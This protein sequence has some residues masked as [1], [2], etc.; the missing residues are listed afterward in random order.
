MAKLDTIYLIMIVVLGFIFNS[1]AMVILKRNKLLKDSL[2]K[3][4]LI[5][6]LGLNISYVIE[7]LSNLDIVP[8]DGA[9]CEIQGFGIC[10]TTFAS[11]GYFLSMTIERYIVVVYRSSTWS[12][13]KKR[14]SFLLA[15]LVG[16]ALAAPPLFGWGKYSRSKNVETYCAFDFDASGMR[17]YFMVV[18]LMVFVVPVVIMTI[19]V[20]KIVLILRKSH[21]NELTNGEARANESLFSLLAGIIYMLSWIPFAIVCFQMYSGVDVSVTFESVAIGL[22]KT[23]VLTSPILFCFHSARTFIAARFQIELPA[24]PP[25][26]LPTIN[27]FRIPTM[28]LSNY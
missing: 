5:A 2:I 10:S 11:V 17:S 23:V 21:D 26:E 8:R 22:S 9:A 7:I 14:L 24:E 15:P 28:N 13:K 18:F 12:S 25:V 27:H 6:N 3:A 20:I 4:F 16:F 19:L 1:V